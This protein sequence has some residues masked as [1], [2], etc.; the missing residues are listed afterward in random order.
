MPLDRIG[1][2]SGSVTM[3]F[4]S[5]LSFLRTR[6]D[7]RYQFRFGVNYRP[8][9]TWTASAQ[10]SYVTNDSNIVINDYDRT[11]FMATLRKEFN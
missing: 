8:A 9:P 6:D 10:V 1:T 5:G 7:N 11:L 3:I 4:V 2:L